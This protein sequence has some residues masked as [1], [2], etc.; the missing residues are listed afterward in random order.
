MQPKIH[1]LFSIPLIIFLYFIFKIPLYGILII[2]FSNI[3][4]DI[5]HFFYYIFKNKKN[6]SIKSFNESYN[7]YKK[8][9][10]FFNKLKKEELKK[11]Y[12]GFYIFHG[13]EFL[14]LV[15]LLSFFNKFFLF[16]L[17]GLTFHYL[18]DL[19]YTLKEKWPLQKFSW[20]YSFLERKKKNCFKVNLK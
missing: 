17:I 10:K 8:K 14:F 5:D 7:W 12:F 13:I 19:I 18:C 1:F 3:L 15:F 11:Y 2:L 4:I 16:I 6:F 20:I 9:S